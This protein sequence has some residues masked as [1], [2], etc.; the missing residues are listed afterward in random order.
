MQTT[1]SALLRAEHAFGFG[2]NP[3]TDN[4]LILARCRSIEQHLNYEFEFD[5][6]Q[7]TTDLRRESSA[8]SARFEHTYGG[9]ALF[10]DFVD[11]DKIPAIINAT[12][13]LGIRMCTQNC[14]YT[15]LSP[16]DAPYTPANEELAFL[17][18]FEEHVRQM[19]VYNS[20]RTRID[21]MRDLPQQL[22]NSHNWTTPEGKAFARALQPLF[23]DAHDDPR[24]RGHYACIFKRYGLTPRLFADDGTLVPAC[25]EDCDA[26]L[27]VEGTG[28]SAPM[29]VTISP[30]L[31]PRPASPTSST[32]PECMICFER[33][34]NTLVLPCQH[35][36]VCRQCSVQLRS[37]ADRDR[38]V[39]C[40]R[41]IDE[42]VQDE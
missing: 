41:E 30:A 4:G 23:E 3:F 32:H 20:R 35:C 28:I 36:V 12:L 2:F 34:P 38:C 40:R 10:V 31:N 16:E 18:Q 8:P 27:R 15:S 14:L 33:P 11:V 25:A 29:T 22:T 24:L 6:K 5:W 42:V 17:H 19:T 9:P 39:Q 37:T 26:T 1:L 7:A 21:F 13:A